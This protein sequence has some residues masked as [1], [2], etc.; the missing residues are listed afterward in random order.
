MLKSEVVEQRL[1]DG[2][3]GLEGIEVL[4]AERG[5]VGSVLAGEGR[6]ILESG[7]PDAATG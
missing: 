4:V 5:A 3:L 7:K 2:K 1:E 6:A